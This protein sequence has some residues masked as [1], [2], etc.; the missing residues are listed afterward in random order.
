[1]QFQYPSVQ[2]CTFTVL[3]VCLLRASFHGN[4]IQTNLRPHYD[5]SVRDLVTGIKSEWTLLI[6]LTGVEDGVEGGEVRKSS[7]LAIDQLK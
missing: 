7:C 3:W 6:Y 2:I 1:M 4:L 5:D